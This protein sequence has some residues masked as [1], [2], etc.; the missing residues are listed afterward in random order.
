MYKISV[1]AIF[2]N[3]ELYAEQCIQSIINQSYRNLEIILVD[4]GS[5]DSCG[6]ICDKYAKLD[7][8]IKVIHKV[9]GGADSARKAG[10]MVATGKYVGFV[11]GDDWIEP[12]MYESLMELAVTYGATV[13]E[14]GL[15]DT[16]GDYSFIRKTKLQEGIYTGAKFDEEIEPYIL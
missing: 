4:D 3:V 14:S 7:S 6:D 12:G 16:A 5:C 11:D 1:I 8:R 2:Y 13:I 9:N 10:I 15:I